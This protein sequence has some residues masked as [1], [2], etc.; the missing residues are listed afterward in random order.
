M[1]RLGSGRRHG[2]GAQLCAGDRGPAP[3]EP[4]P[5]SGWSSTFLPYWPAVCEASLLEGPEGQEGQESL[6]EGLQSPWLSWAPPS[7]L[8]DPGEVRSLRTRSPC[9]RPPHSQAPG[10]PSPVTRLFRGHC[11]WGGP[12]V[13][14]VCLVGT[15][16]CSV[17]SVPIS[18][19]ELGPAPPGP[20]P[21]MPQAG[22]WRAPPSWRSS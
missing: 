22:C 3:R 6:K 17:G 10:G 8:P 14:G 21:Q 18:R 16:L 11:E 19:M 13:C 1:P 20:C 15:G 2:G 9:S 7:R 5:G 12:R 4:V